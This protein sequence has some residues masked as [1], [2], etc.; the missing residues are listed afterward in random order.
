M[1][2]DLHSH[3]TASDGTYSPQ[4]LLHL[5]KNKGIEMF[6]ITDHDTLSGYLSVKELAGA[7]GLSLIAGVEITCHHTLTGGYGKNTQCNKIIHVVALNVKGIERLQHTLMTIQNSRATRG[8]QIVQK[9]ASILS[10]N[11][12]ELWHLCLQ[13]VDG[14]DKAL[15]RAHIAQVLHELGVVKTIQQAFD[16]YL[17]DGKLA[18]VAI[19]SLT[20]AQTIALIHQC[21]GLAV[22]AHPTRYNLSATRI[23]RLIADFASLGG[24]AVELPN[25]SEPISTRRMVDRSVAEYGLWVSVGSDFHGTTMPWRKLGEVATL[26]HGQTGVWERFRTF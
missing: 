13:K 23:R 18:Y 1:Q 9:L 12:D 8:Q 10:L 3:T 16:K 6:A 25:P 26:A 7:M 17:A 21:G 5:A 11:A 22:L 14:N 15:G 4:E 24:N 20:M 2:I 19:D